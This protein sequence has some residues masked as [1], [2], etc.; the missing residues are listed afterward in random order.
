MA[1]PSHHLT[2]VEQSHRMSCCLRSGQTRRSGHRCRAQHAQHGSRHTVAQHETAVQRYLWSGSG[3]R[4]AHLDHCSRHRYQRACNVYAVP[5]AVPERVEKTTCAAVLVHINVEHQ[6]PQAWWGSLQP[7]PACVCLRS[8]R[9]PRPSAGLVMLQW[10]LS[11]H[12]SSL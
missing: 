7:F 10:Q 2:D 4:S 1:S 3:C 11:Y 5:A 8:V 12:A 6:A 9:A